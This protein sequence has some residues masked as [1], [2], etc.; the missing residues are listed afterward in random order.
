MERIGPD[1]NTFFFMMAD[2]LALQALI[3]WVR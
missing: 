1:W 3:P 2:G